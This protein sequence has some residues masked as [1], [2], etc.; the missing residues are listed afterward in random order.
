MIRV[1]PFC[2]LNLL[3]CNLREEPLYL[4]WNYATLFAF[5]IL[6]KVR[7]FLLF[8]HLEETLC[9]KIK[10]LFP[11]LDIHPLL[12]IYLMQLKPTLGCIF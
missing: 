4:L 3:H 10:S 7:P 8:A 6:I 5:S 9:N 1:I 2:F 11:S 12:I